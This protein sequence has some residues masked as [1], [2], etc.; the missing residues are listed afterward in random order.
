MNMKFLLGLPARQRLSVLAYHRVLA[1][2]D[3]LL[4]EEPSAAEFERRMRWV[5]ANFN[6]MPL[7]EA[8]RAL[9]ED[10]LPPRALCITFDDGYADNF[11]VAFPILQRLGLPATFF[12]ATG[13][14]D[15]GCMF[16]DVVIEAVRAALS[17]GLD[18]DDLALGRHVL[19]SDEQR[20]RAIARIL[21]RLRYFEPSR[22]SEV[23]REVARRAGARIRTD[24]MMT[25][26]QV[27]ALHAAGMEVGAH[28]V[29][30]PIL[31]EIGVQRARHEMAASRARLEEITGAPVRLFAYPNGTPERDYRGE[32][33]ALARE[34][35]F[36]AAVSAAWGA[37]RAGD[38]LYQIPRFTPWDRADWRFG[39]RM[40]RNLMRHDY[41]RA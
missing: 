40:A 22:R 34:V 15:G 33:A 19:G 4:A 41:A 20:A 36:D 3:P 29:S 28:T 26:A 17:P 6:V 21:A 8:V 38:D 10:R 1:E 23:A 9:R 13:F 11:C 25:S 39:L 7:G 30:H 27:R 2:R 32:H 18:L 12:I 37:A 5:K 35:G 24:L 14:L 31:A 16:N